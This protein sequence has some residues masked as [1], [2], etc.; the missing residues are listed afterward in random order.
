MVRCVDH[1]VPRVRFEHEYVF[2]GHGNAVAVSSGYAMELVSRGV[3][4]EHSFC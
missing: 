3:R 4:D 1:T 2:Y